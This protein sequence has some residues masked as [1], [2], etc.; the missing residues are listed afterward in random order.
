[1]VWSPQRPVGWPADSEEASN[2]SWPL[3]HQPARL[4]TW[5]SRHGLVIP[6]WKTTVLRDSRLGWPGHCENLFQ[7]EK[8][9][10][11]AL[12]AKACLEDP[13]CPVWQFR[14][15]EQT[16]WVGFGVRCEEGLG[17]KVEAQRLLH[18]TV[19]VV[20][21]LTGAPRSCWSLSF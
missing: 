21:Q 10:S 9:D 13:R 15:R 17:E 1:M 8:L 6:C 16:C 18:G 20:R 19:Y 3:G 11:A 12:C 4:E 7:L 5:G 2:A 14:L